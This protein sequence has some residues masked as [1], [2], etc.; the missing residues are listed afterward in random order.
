MKFVFEHPWLLVSGVVAIPMVVLGL[1]ALRYTDRARRLALPTVRLLLVIAIAL[2][3]A[4]PSMRREHHDISVIALLDV[5]GSARAFGTI[6]DPGADGTA[7]RTYLGEVRDWLRRAIGTRG[8]SD[9]FGVVVFDGTAIAA[10]VP[11]RADWNEAALDVS[12]TPGTSLED[13]IRLGIALFPPDAAR[14]LVL[15][16]DGNETRGDAL[17]AARDAAATASVPIDVLPVAYSVIRD[18]QVVR[19]DAPPTARAGETIDVRIVIEATEAMTGELSLTRDGIGLDI[20]GDVPGRARPV[21]LPAGESVHVATVVVGEAPVHQYEAIFVPDVA[22]DDALDRNN[23]AQTVVSTPGRGRV[24]LVTQGGASDAGPLASLLRAA[25][26]DVRVVSPSEMPDD[27]ITLQNHDLVVLDNIPAWAVPAQR[28]ELLLRHVT[29]LGAGLLVVGGGNS[30][31]AG[32][33][34]GAPLE[35]ILPLELDPPADL[36]LPQAA[37][38]LVLDKSGSMA[39]SVAGARRSSQQQIANEAAAAAVESLNARS[40]V[41]VI[42]FSDGARTVVPL[43]RNEDADRIVNEILAIQ[44]DGGTNIARA[45]RASHEMLRGVDADR[46]RVVLLTDGQSDASAFESIAES[47]VNDGIKITTIAVGDDA[48]HTALRGLAEAGGGEFYPIYNPNALPRVLVDSVQVINRPLIKESPFV[49]V[50]EPTGSTMTVGLDR[51]PKAEALV[52]TAPRDDPRAVIELTHPDGEPLLAHWQ[53]GL[54]RVAVFTSDA[55]RSWTS[56]WNEFAPAG[57]FWVQL[58]RMTQRATTGRSG[59]LLAEINGDQLDVSFEAVDD[60]DRYVDGLTVDGQVYGPDG[61]GQPVRIPQVAPGLYRLS[62]PAPDSGNYIVAVSPR[63]GEQRLPP[64]IAA[65]T[66]S[67][68][69]E[70][71][72]YRSNL[73]LL[74]AI[75]ERSS[76]RRLDPSDPALV[77]LFDRSALPTTVSFRPLTT[78][79]LLLCVVLLLLDVAAR[80]LAWSGRGVREQA[81]AAVKA[82]SAARRRGA[83]AARTLGD[84]RAGSNERAPGPAVVV[85]HREQPVGEQRSKEPAA[86]PESDSAPAPRGPTAEEAEEALRRVL[87]RG[88]STSSPPPTD[89]PASETAPPP[90]ETTSDLL[91]ARRRA[92]RD[93]DER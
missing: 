68:G 4:V 6:P 82:E 93:L 55:G 67:M 13:A 76:G 91:A 29:D 33:W 1:I 52:I 60:E 62:L 8:E 54:G 17:A 19:V 21:S 79:L 45:L 25:S 92:R 47:M 32:G 50:I 16:S 51:A 2:A 89:E 49:P 48:D 53:A 43:Q 46:K 74:D 35:P 78:A 63:A 75:V 42:A 41:G 87:G 28:Q 18:A 86:E 23:R 5:S 85:D 71:R 77:D 59:T 10:S 27:L 64:A 37:L 44:P 90:A 88:G 38:V 14:R 81:A 58:A 40:L 66:R 24:L 26:V 36:V 61:V 72:S 39:F 73:A 30:L 15:I 9:R 3:L 70:F 56:T 57:T 12:V 83:E 34:N 7:P 11:T 31:G 22:D 20:N 69:E 65:T 80:R 84:L